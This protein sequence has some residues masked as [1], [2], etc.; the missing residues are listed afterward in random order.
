[1]SIGDY[2]TKE[3]EE[4]LARRKAPRTVPPF[5]TRLA[6][7]D[8]ENVSRLAEEILDTLNKTRR[9]DD[10]YSLEMFEAVMLAFYGPSFK[11]WEEYNVDR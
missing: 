1:M 11:A 5:P 7:P 10:A 8:G 2:T 6:Y 9:W 4:E 3:L